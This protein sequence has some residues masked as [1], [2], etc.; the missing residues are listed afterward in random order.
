LPKHVVA[1]VDEIPPGGRKVVEVGGRSV[2]IFNVNGEYF[3]LRNRCPHQGG[4][5]CAGR[6]AG[7]L[8]SSVPGEYKYSRAGEMVRCP[9]HGWEFDMRTGQSWFDPKLR[10][11]RYDVTVAPGSELAPPAEPGTLPGEAPS[12][13]VAVAVPEGMEG[14]EPGPYTAETYPVSI[15]K[16]Y[17]V[18]DVR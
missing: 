9:W 1:T 2:G 4:P 14:L 12:S 8:T 6:T 10:V 16:S 3:A 11:R 5:L 13:S 18:V 7:F 15:E 17:V